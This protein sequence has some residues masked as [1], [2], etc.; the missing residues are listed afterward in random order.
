MDNKELAKLFENYAV[1]LTLLNEN[2]FKIRAFENA[3]AII[4][5]LDKDWKTLS[6]DEWKKIKGI[7][8]GIAE[9]MKQIKENKTWKDYEE[10]TGKIPG[11]VLEM[12][13]I[14][15]IGTQTVKKLWK[16]FGISSPG[17][18]LYACIE[19]RLNNLPGFG[20]KKQEKIKSAVEFYLKNKDKT[21]FATIYPLAE[22][23]L[24]NL[25]K[26]YPDEKFA[27][28][29]EYRRKCEII[30]K[31]QLLSTLDSPGEYKGFKINGIELEWIVTQKKH[32]TYNL[33]VSSAHRLHIKRIGEINQDVNDEA[34]IY[35]KN[36]LPYIIPEMREGL[37]EFDW[38]EKFTND[39]LVDY[40]DIKGV[41]HCHSKY[42]DGQHTIREMAEK[43]ISLGFE[44]LVITDHSQSA[45]Y[46]NGLNPERVL[47]QHLEIDDLNKTYENFKIFKGIE[48][49]ILPD[50]SLDYDENILKKFDL[51]IAS[52]HSKINMT[53][54]EAT[55]RLIKAIENPY[56]KILGH[57]TG[58]LL[59]TREG[60]SLDWPKVLDACRA[61]NVAIELNANPHR[62]D[63]DWRLIY[64]CLE[65]GLMI[66]INPD[67][68]NIDEI[69]NIQYGVWVARKGGLVKSHTL[70]CL[71]LPQFYHWIK[72]Y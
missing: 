57:P 16:E 67:A 66:S 7:G 25:Q 28:T 69:E 12:V 58:R 54:Q 56:T 14:R 68:H 49:D 48:S 26:K 37:K 43:T 29:G 61:N 70:N 6:F 53:K 27:W 4:E 41:I 35:L 71:T 50:G 62:L 44:Y 72:K 10:I 30:E 40:K 65:K 22:S 24:E 33:F 42:S 31:L 18:L 20:P 8:K 19:N 23:F 39:Q 17:E 2:P 3:A 59:L 34:T 13:N 21:L 51:V 5:R 11:G 46:A 47:L 36:N 52:V 9:V 38:A 63:I 55:K 64:D 45:F 32:W 1:M 15:G 60:Y